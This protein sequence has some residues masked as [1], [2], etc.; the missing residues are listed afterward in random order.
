MIQDMLH[1]QKGINWNDFSTVCKRGTACIK[2]YEEEGHCV[3]DCGKP[4]GFVVDK[5]NSKWILDTEMPIL[6]G[7]DRAYIDKLI[8]IGE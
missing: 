2:K 1:E 8:Y 5:V 7:E 4:T 6:K 3:V